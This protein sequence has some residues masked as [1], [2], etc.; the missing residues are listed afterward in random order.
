VSGITAVTPNS[1]TGQHT[2]G[3]AARPADGRSAAPEP[4]PGRNVIERAF[5]GFKH[6]CD[7]ATG[8]DK[9]ATGQRGGLVLAASLSWLALRRRYVLARGWIVV[10][11]CPS[12]RDPEVDQ[13]SHRGR[14]RT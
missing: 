13:V 14:P 2:A 4:A 7:L 1:T 8:Y 6:W 10:A 11:M 5:D 3:V 9:H 12:L